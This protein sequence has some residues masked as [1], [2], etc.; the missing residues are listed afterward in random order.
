MIDRV[1][2][3]AIMFVNAPVISPSHCCNP[4]LAA[5]CARPAPIALA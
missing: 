5:L 1:I 3:G 4:P 2:D